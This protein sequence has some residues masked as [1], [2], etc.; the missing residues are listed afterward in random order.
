MPAQQHIL[1]FECD[2]KPLIGMLHQ[3]EQA[4][5][6]GLLC[7]VAGG[8]QYRVGCCRQQVILARSLA[9]QGIPVM[10]FDYRGMGDAEG[11]LPAD[12]SDDIG[13]AIDAFLQAAPEL[14][15]IVL[16]GGCDGASAV[17]ISGWRHP[18]VAG[19]ILNNPYVEEEKAQ[20]KVALKHYYVGRLRSRD[21]W[22]KVLR[23]QFDVS[24]SAK[25]LWGSAR[26]AFGRNQKN[27]ET[28]SGKDP[29]DPSVPFTQRMLRGWQ[30]FD[31]QVMLLMGGRSIVAREFDECVANNA[32][33]QA[34]VHTSRVKRVELKEADHTF[35]EPASRAALSAAIA[36]WMLKTYRA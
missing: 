15:H 20:A 36:D 24:G 34:V 13:A 27:G 19:W 31:G 2:A 28:S 21:F 1:Q 7:I 18:A 35:S 16:Y 4:I 26:T 11:E 14:K 29:F 23:L 32:D 22:N 10:R 30:R 17:A 8:A 5:D 9:E 12:R 3:P 6:T 25:A 33:W